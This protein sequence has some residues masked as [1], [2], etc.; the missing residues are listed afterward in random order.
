MKSIFL[1]SSVAVAAGWAYVR[2][3]QLPAGPTRL[4]W[5]G[6]VFGHRG[7]R[8]VPGV[9]ENTLDAFK[10]ALSRG[11]AGI[12]VDVR[13]TKDSELAVFHDVTCNGHLKGVAATT[14]IDELTL[15]ELKRLPFQADPTRQIRLPTLE[16][17][18]LFCREN[19]LKMLIEIKEM[20]RARLCADK[21]LDLY[22]RYPDYMY[23][24]TV[25]VSFNPA[26]LYYVRNRDRNVAVGQIHS[27]RALRT[28]IRTGT[29]DVPW[30]A[31]LCPAVLDWLLN[32]V[33]ESVNPWLSGV[34]LMCPHHELFSE[35]YKHRW[36]TRKIGVALWGFSSPAQCTR[37]MRA[38]GVL[39]ESDDQHEE[40]AT[41]KQ[42][43]NFD[44]FG[45][46]A[47]ERERE[48]EEQRRRLK[49]EAK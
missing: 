32:Y 36:H 38:P 4:D 20:R 29:I 9:P 49:L 6:R 41:P 8:G 5:G 34:S 7:C 12:E 45:D 11:V 16:E 13:L 30:Y 48:E 15:L 19:N 46:K 27:G 3:I 1:A 10:Y 44:I 35:V 2:H 26:L 39:V 40:F 31:R 22:H 33:Q 24:H 18:L 43:A 14:R 47:R 28:W 17:S 42:P 23:E 25:V 37:E 21:V